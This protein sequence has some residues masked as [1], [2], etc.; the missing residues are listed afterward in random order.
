M[1]KC[2]LCSKDI[3]DK[4]KYCSDKCRMAFTRTV[5]PE[6]IQPEQAR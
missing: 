6:Q 2:L 1:N 3:S 5:Q 4:A